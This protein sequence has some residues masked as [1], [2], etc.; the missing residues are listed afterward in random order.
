MLAAAR[1]LCA[2]QRPVVLAG[3]GVLYAQASTQ[4][5]ALAELLS[6][7]VAT[8]LLG[9][10]AF[11]E[12][13]PLAL[14]CASQVTTQPAAEFIARADLILSVGSS[15]TRHA[16]KVTLPPGVPIVQINSDPPTCTR[17]I[18]SST[19]SWVMLDSFSTS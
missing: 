8:T 10:S 1:A 4:L 13:H 14:G 17:T 5:V 19:R 7:P 9:K 2:A 11:P 12:T 16:T 18:Q 15:L 6:L 3:Q